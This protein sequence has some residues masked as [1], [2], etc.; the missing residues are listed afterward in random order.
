MEI[1]V[2]TIDCYSS[3]HIIRVY[4]DVSVNPFIV[5]ETHEETSR[6]VHRVIK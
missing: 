5:R 3:V 4:N 2:C 1:L 6:G